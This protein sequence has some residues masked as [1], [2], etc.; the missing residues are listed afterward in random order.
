[1]I[2]YHVH[3][4]ESCSLL[5]VTKKNMKKKKKHHP[6]CVHVMHELKEPDKEK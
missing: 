1:M 2:S 3:K 4:M 6:Y 5:K